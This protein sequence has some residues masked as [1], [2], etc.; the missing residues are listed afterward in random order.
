MNILQTMDDP[1]LFGP[2]FKHTDTWTAWR[3]FLATLFALPFEDRALHDRCTDGR[4]LSERQASEAYLII[5]RRG[6]K[7]FICAPPQAR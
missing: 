2:W 1:N 6:G 4:P 5:G 3:V 7:S